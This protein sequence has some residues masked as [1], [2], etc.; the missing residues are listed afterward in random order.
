MSW[1]FIY[2]P[3]N[4][5]C[6]TAIIKILAKKGEVLRDLSVLHQLL[7]YSIILN[8]ALRHEFLSKAQSR[9]LQEVDL[10]CLRSTIHRRPSTAHPSLQQGGNGRDRSF[11]DG[12]RL[13]NYTALLS[14]VF[15]HEHRHQEFKSQFKFYG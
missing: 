10:D 14:V 8:T 3:K 13:E 4:F 11:D 1:Q 5:L 15:L 9:L 12:P 6:N 7:T 2:L